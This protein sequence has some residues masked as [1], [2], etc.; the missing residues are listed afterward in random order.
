[1]PCL[2]L[3]FALI[4]YPAIFFAVV[5]P[6]RETESVFNFILKKGSPEHAREGTHFLKGC[7]TVQGTLLRFHEL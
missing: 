1:M 5:N 6:T 7:H 3:F 4:F 2:V